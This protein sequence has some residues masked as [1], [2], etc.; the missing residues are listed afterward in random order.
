MQTNPRTELR[1]GMSLVS[2]L[3]RNSP[4]QAVLFF[5]TIS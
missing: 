3:P 4:R 2:I 1:G 5:V